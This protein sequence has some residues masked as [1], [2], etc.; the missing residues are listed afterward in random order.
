METF[1]LLAPTSP[2]P[3][4]ILSVLAS[5]FIFC[6]FILLVCVLL[7]FG[8]FF[9]PFYILLPV[10]V[11]SLSCLFANSFYLSVLSFLSVFASQITVSV[12]QGHVRSPS[13]QPRYKSYAYTQAAYVK[14]PEQKR[15]RFTEQVRVSQC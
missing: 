7:L 13:P 14:S 5:A 1:A 15:R 2:F 3:T 12:A 11:L 9:T 4:C 10:S 6:F 8:L